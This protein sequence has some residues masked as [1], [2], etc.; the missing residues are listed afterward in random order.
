MVIPFE[1]GALGTILKESLEELKI[2]ERI[3]IMQTIG[4]FRS[5]RILKRVSET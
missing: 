1:I 3:E 2:G 5:T 4:L